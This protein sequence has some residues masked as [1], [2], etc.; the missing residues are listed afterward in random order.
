MNASDHR[1]LTPPPNRLAQEK[2]PYLLQHAHN[3]VTWYPWG[4]E[5]FAQ[6]RREKKPIFLSV[7]YS[8]CHWC[9]V[10]AHESFEDAAIA[11]LLNRHFVSIKVDREERPEI[12]RL[13]MA[14][15]QAV[16][17]GGG[18]WP[19]SVWLTPELK[20]FYGGTYFPPEDRYGR[21]GFGRVLESLA[22]AWR[23]ARVQIEEAGAAAIRQ[24]QAH[25]SDAAAPE[26]A[27]EAALT[28]AAAAFMSSYDPTHGGFGGAP[29]FPRPSVF[30]FLLRHHANTG[31]R[32]PLDAVLHTLRAMADG[33]I[34]DHLGGGFHR[35]ATDERWLIPHFEKMLYD[36]AQLVCA[37][38][39]AYQLTGETS[40]ADVARDTLAYVRRDLTG[41]GGQ[42]YSAEDADS[43]VPSEPGASAEGAFYMW[44]VTELCDVLGQKEGRFFGAAF[45]TD[46]RDNVVDNRHVLAV[47]RDGARGLLARHRAALQAARAKRPRPQRDDKA[48]AAWNGLMISACARAYQALDDPADL[49]SAQRAAAFVK[50]YL[51][52]PASGHLL[53]SFRDGAAGV[54][55]FAEDT[56]FMI[57]GLLDLYESD[58]EPGH[59]EWALAL[60]DKQDALFWDDASGGYFSSAAD[61]ADVLIRMKETHDG[62]EP[63]AGAVAALNLR[64]LASL[65]GSARYRQRADALFTCF[66]R[67]LREQPES[68][69]QMLAALS[70]SQ[71]APQ[72]VVVAGHP[73]DADT[74]A[75]L[76]VVRRRFSPNRIVL[77][78][79]GGAGQAFLTRFQSAIGEMRKVDGRAAAYVCR[80]FVCREPVA[81]ADKL[82]E[83]LA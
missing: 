16:T 2:S 10:M 26:P 62:A 38:L 13:Y 72:Q 41:P 56:A 48:L 36:Q 81:E 43:P 32:P 68:V 1:K 79:D 53:R 74:R 23:T 63:S 67:R 50:R 40:F 25:L 34:R 65:T 51:Y 4:E 33:G 20:P 12:D 5:A 52:D 82:A 47:S 7:G 17:R 19:M 61:A 6:A 66:G 78:A 15:V 37:Y 35:Y 44:T 54:S 22:E 31:D 49:F 69:P 71:S 8:T 46:R 57:Q 75:L 39:E 58:F 76:R 29:K 9:H 14:Y 83:L 27:G 59:L 77:L 60:Q 11:G 55:G 21:P 80:D 45:G 24:L 28:D 18:G 3:P 64:R 70:A 73:E 42:F 30:A